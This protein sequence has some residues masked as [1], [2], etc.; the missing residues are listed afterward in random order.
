VSGGGFR[1][2]VSAMGPQ[3]AIA[4]GAAIDRQLVAA[5]LCPEWVGMLSFMI[6]TLVERVGPDDAA[7]VLIRTVA[8]LRTLSADV[9]AAGPG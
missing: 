5:G 2:N 8:M 6:G 4:E 3:S 9:Q 7:D 1:I